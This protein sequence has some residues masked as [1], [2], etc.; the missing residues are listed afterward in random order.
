MHKNCCCNHS[1]W[2]RGELKTRFTLIVQFEYRYQL[3]IGGGS[4]RQVTG[5][6]I[7]CF[8]NYY[9]YFIFMLRKA[10]YQVL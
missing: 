9:W 4:D 2:E 6:I 1:Q 3:T 5:K 7:I 8:A 10:E